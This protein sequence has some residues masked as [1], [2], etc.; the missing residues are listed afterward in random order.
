MPALGRR[1]KQADIYEFKI[2]LDYKVNSRQSGLNYTEK[3]CLRE[4]GGSNK[5]KV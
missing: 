4:R 2:S 3:A 5:K 1:Q